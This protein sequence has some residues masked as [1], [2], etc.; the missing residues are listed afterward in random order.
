MNINKKSWLAFAMLL[1]LLGNAILCPS[2]FC[3]TNV[4]LTIGTDNDE[5]GKLVRVGNRLFVIGS[6]WHDGSDDFYVAA[7]DNHLNVR[8][9]K[10]Y[11]LG[12]REKALEMVAVSDNHFLITGYSA[13]GH[14]SLLTEIDSAGAV[15]KSWGF[16]VYQ[17]RLQKIIPANDGGFLYYGELEGLLTGDNKVAMIKYNANLQVEWKQYYDYT[18]STDNIDYRE[19]YARTAV[20]LA[21]S[22]FM[23]LGSYT[24]FYSAGK[25]RKI[26][27]IKIDKNGNLKWVKGFHGGKMDNAI[28]M[29]LCS[30][31]GVIIAANSNSYSVNGDTDI[32]LI[33]TNSAGELEW[34]KTYGTPGNDEVGKA[35]ELP[36]NQGYIVCG[37]ADS[38]GYGKKDAL[39]FKLKKQGQL[40][41][42]RAFGGAG[43]D[44][45]INVDTLAN[46]LY[47]SGESQGTGHKDIYVLKTALTDIKGACSLDVTSLLTEKAVTSTF[48]QGTYSQHTFTTPDSVTVTGNDVM[49]ARKVICSA[50]SGDSSGTISFGVGSLHKTI[51]RY[52]K[53]EGCQSV[54]CAQ[55][56]Y[57]NSDKN[58]EALKKSIKIK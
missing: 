39:L 16:G 50:R 20:Q 18:G 8:W 30:D 51:E 54:V 7:L 34:M 3:Q 12:G 23:V 26:R 27:L 13:N 53:S 47:V 48:Y 9:S 40:A 58:G 4:Q 37:S 28:H 46:Q 6:T 1:L 33:K 2:A 22:S 10:R 42:A 44:V 11:S 57:S 36:D 43:N 56:V 52:I 15:I 55:C 25:D 32:L 31:G 14:K 45:F 29:S 5:S 21:D 35:M 49:S 17:D 41:E 24:K 38:L 19:M